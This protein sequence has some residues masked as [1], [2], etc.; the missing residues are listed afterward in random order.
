MLAQILSLSAKDSLATV[1]RSTKADKWYKSIKAWD[2]YVTM[3]FCVL[4]G[5][6]SLREIG[7]G[8]EAFGAKLNHLGL[9]KVP[10]RSTLADANK[11]RSSE[12][13][14]KIYCEL[15]SRYR[16]KLSD[17]SLSPA[18]LSKLFVVDATVFSLFKAILKGP[19]RTPANGK[20]KGGIKKHT[21]LNGS[22]LMPVLV[23]FTAAASSDQ[24][25]IP[26]VKLPPG[27]F[28]TFDK[29]YTSYQW[30]R[31]LTIQGV[32]FITRQKE[33]AVYTTVSEAILTD[34]TASQ[35]LKDEIIECICK[36][37]DGN[38]V[39]FQMRRVAWWDEKNQ[40][41]FEYITNNFELNAAT[42]AE[43][44]Q[45][46][47][48]IEL[49]FK[50]LKQNFGLT[51]FVGDNQNAIEIQIWCALI[52]VLLLSAIHSGNKSKIAFSNVVTLLRIHLAGYISIPEL[53]RLHNKKRTRGRR[54]LL[55]HNELF[56][57]T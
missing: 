36:D 16:L 52:G 54:S 26:D 7:M 41:A 34:T 42:I 6:S 5:C 38:E 14:A 51:Y 23:K 19:G 31:A 39:P 9:D 8:L 32:Y 29:G 30:Y 12:V 40:R 47:W 20:R 1:F 35:V 46:R 33:D 45:Y 4:S 25:I 2:H 22:S 57:Q 43:I 3:M 17:S 49:F 24:H 13:F 37:K 53:L 11:K 56:A 28:I 15:V 55:V 18:V 50:K 10:A 48:Q 21:I 44:Y 27:S